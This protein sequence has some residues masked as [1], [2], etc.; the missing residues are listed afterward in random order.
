MPTLPLMIAAK[1][2]AS[3]A[4]KLPHFQAGAAGIQTQ[5]FNFWQLFSQ[6]KWHRN[7]IPAQAG[8][9]R[10]LPL[11]WI[12]A[13]AGMTGKFADYSIRLKSCNFCKL[14]IMAAVDD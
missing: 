12:P 11:D 10:D 2:P 1:K 5:Y 4:G 14:R 7:V 13:C 8:I 9:Q 3:P 6:V